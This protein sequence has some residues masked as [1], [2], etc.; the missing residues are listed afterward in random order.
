VSAAEAVPDYPNQLRLDGRVVIVL[1]AGAGIGRQCSHALAQ[2]GATVVCVG[3]RIEPVEALAEEIGGVAVTADVIRRDGMEHV[4]AEAGRIGPVSGLVD[5]VGRGLMGPVLSYDDSRYDDQFDVVLR[6]AFLALRIGG[7]AIAEAGGGAMV[8]I[9]SVA[10]HTFAPGQ[11]VYGAAK[12][13]LHRMVESAGHELAPLGVR[14]NV[15]APG[16]THTPRLDALF[17]EAR[18]ARVDANIPRGSA[19]AASEI[20]GPVLFL[21]SDLASYLTGQTITVDGGL[22]GTIPGLF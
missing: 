1:G 12:A 11:I 17:D 21:M 14:V 5:I 19:G 18:W 4:V 22:T 13:A 10:G 8:F 3:R 16:V 7:Q 20:A 9:G 2:A 15:V 6:H